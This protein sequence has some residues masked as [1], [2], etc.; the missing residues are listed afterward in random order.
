MTVVLRL[1]GSRCHFHF[2]PGLFLFLFEDNWRGFTEDII[3]KST[4]SGIR[5]S[6]DPGS[7][8]H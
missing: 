2:I 5:L 6:S 8:T 3:F 1:D 4:G 7:N